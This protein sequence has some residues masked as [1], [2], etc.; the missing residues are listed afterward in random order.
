MYWVVQK[1]LF[2]EAEQHEALLTALDRMG[3]PFSVHDCVMGTLIPNIEPEGPVMVIGAVGMANIAQRRGWRPG[4][5][6]N[7]NFDFEVQR[8]QWGDRML[9]ADALVC[10]FEDVPL[11]RDE[12][13][14]ED[15][16]FFIRPV[17]DTK[18]FTGIVQTWDEFMAWHERIVKN[19]EDMRWACKPQTPVLIGLAKKLYW[20]YRLFV[21]DGKVV[22]A[23]AYKNGGR[24]WVTEA[25]NPAAIQFVEEA[26]A[27]WSPARA[28]VADVAETPDGLRLIE[29]NNLNSAGFYACN[30]ARLVEAIEGMGYT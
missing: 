14:L 11:H 17:H 8:A 10:A 30:I 4:S 7:G 19:D 25:V 24:L 9:N 3:L 23:S 26:A 2:R 18:S 22:T 27:C 28:F 1:D 16:C 12:I 15:E 29:V 6:L 20:E 5:F 13:R 21:V